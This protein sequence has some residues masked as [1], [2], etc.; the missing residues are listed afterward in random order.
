VFY[1]NDRPVYE[2][3]MSLQLEE[4]LAKGPGDLDKLIRGRET[5]EIK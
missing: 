3:M 5:W 4:A 1:T 2:D